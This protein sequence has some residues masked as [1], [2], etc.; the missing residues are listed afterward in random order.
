MASSSG[1]SSSSFHEPFEKAYDA[2]L[3]LASKNARKHSSLIESLRARRERLKNVPDDDLHDDNDTFYEKRT[4]DLEY[5]LEPIE[6]AFKSKHASMEERAVI[7]LTSLIGGRMITGRCFEEEEDKED[8]EDNE[9]D[10]KDYLEKEDKEKR[11][12]GGEKTEQTR[13]ERLCAKVVDLLCFACGESGDESVELQALL[14]VLACYMSRSFRVSG[15]MLSRMIESVCKCHAISRSETNRGVAKA[16]LVQMIFANFTRVEKGDSSAFSKMVKVSDV[17]GGGGGGGVGGRNDAAKDDTKDDVK[18]STN[19]PSTSYETHVMRENSSVP[20]ISNYTSGQHHHW[21]DEIV[22]F[23]QKFIAKAAS[24]GKTPQAYAPHSSEEKK[25]K[26]ENDR[27][28]LEDCAE[29][30]RALSRIAKGAGLK[31]ANADA[32]SISRGKLLALDALRIA[33]Q[34]VGNAFVDD[35]IFSDTIREYVLDAVVSNA[36]SETVQAPELYKI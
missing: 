14:G 8:K 17:L 27:Y 21:S 34:N 6:I 16:A 25:A 11:R 5:F 32:A 12:V 24:C 36:I 19:L 31:T 3:E 23:A 26:A 15:K 18:D 7:C 22:T 28:I 4:E 30:F 2:L 33:C 29:I 20:T 9:E 10:S 1:S 13:R 35:P